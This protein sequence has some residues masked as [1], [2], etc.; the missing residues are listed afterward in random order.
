MCNATLRPHLN[1]KEEV[2]FT[3][4]RGAQPQS[5][6]GIY[7]PNLHACVLRTKS[8]STALTYPHPSPYHTIHHPPQLCAVVRRVGE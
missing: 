5:V 1:T 2:L 3:H 6:H 8:G 7:Q 4:R